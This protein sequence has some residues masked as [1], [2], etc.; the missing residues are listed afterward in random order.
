MTTAL[1][2]ASGTSVSVLGSRSRKSS[3]AGLR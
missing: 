3:T 1:M 2:S